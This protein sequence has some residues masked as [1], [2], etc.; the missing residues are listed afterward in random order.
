MIKYFKLDGTPNAGK[1]AR[2]VWSRGKA[3]DYIKCLPIATDSPGRI[4]AF[5]VE[6]IELNGSLFF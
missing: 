3:G 1:L 4:I 5:F 6:V 2:S